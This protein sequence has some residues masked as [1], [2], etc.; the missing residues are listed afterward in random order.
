MPKDEQWCYLLNQ[1]CP[2][3]LDDCWQ[4]S[5]FQEINDTGNYQVLCETT[6]EGNI[7]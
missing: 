1:E 5:V 7:R 2:L 4:C 3:E 6:R